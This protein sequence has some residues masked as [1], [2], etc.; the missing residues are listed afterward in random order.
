MII[1]IPPSRFVACLILVC[2][3][4][5]MLQRLF[6][7]LPECGT[8]A[9]C[10]G[11]MDWRARL[12]VGHGVATALWRLH[13]VGESYSCLQPPES[14]DLLQ[15][16]EHSIGISPDGRAEVMWMGIS[17]LS[18]KSA[19]RAATQDLEQF[20]H[21]LHFLLAAPLNRLELDVR[22]QGVGGVWPEEVAELVRDLA[23]RC[24]QGDGHETNLLQDVVTKF[25]HVLIAHAPAVPPLPP[26]RRT[27][28][29]ALL[30]H[31][32]KAC[33]AFQGSLEALCCVCLEP[34]EKRSGLLCP[35]EH[36]NPLLC[37]D[38]LEPYVSSLIGTSE[39]RR[40]EG[41]TWNCCDSGC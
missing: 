26:M 39:L 24:L 5:K 38:C 41:P 15:L 20:G 28:R 1:F 2:P 32:F 25:A 35:S 27:K 16:S 29:W 17:S 18:Q 10:V 4:C 30:R 12:L 21:V 40:Q 8:L 33:W 14:G 3:F 7:A 36:K 31:L 22:E 23:S 11:E 19:G 6:Y 37:F 13:S 9:N 34:S